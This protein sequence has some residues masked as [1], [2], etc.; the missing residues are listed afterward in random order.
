[1]KLSQRLETVA[2][3]VSEGSNLA[4]IGTDHGYIP[5]ALV[6]RGVVPSA[7]AIDVRPGP[8]K[9]AADHIAEYHL[10]E[11]IT[12]R[13]GDGLTGLNPGEADTVVIAGMG[14]E[15]VIHILEEGHHLW[16]DVK[17][18][19]LSPQSEL[20][21]VRS[22]LAEHGFS[23]SREDMVEEDGKYYTVMDVS[24][25]TM[26]PMSPAACLYGPGLIETKNP[27]LR[28]FLERERKQIEQILEQLAGRETETARE[29]RFQLQLQLEW[30]KEAEYEMR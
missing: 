28:R 20:D 26:K 15:L 25:G 2:S 21:K 24:R 19:V 30:V 18:W 3:F 23:I 11:K 13:L 12:T 5:I 22:Y 6:L 8:L 16:E 17:Q 10:E 9:R 29:R 1:M 14:G 7:I 27:V 4:D